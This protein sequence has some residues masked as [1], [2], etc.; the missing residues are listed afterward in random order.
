MMPGGEGVVA[1]R[2]SRA[3]WGTLIF[4]YEG[5]A[6]IRKLASLLLLLGA[7]YLGAD[8]LGE[9]D[10][11]RSDAAQS[12]TVSV[13]ESGASNGVLARAFAQHR[14]DVQV[15]GRGRVLKVLEDDRDGSQHQRFLLALDEGFTVLVA[16]NIDL[17]PRVSGLR[18]GDRVT[19]S[20]EYEWND[21]GGVVHWTH[22]DPAG[23]HVSGWLKH[24]GHT[25]Q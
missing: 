5:L 3:L 21:K 23:R 22:R 1:R 4:L 25:F 10:A 20:G 11:G 15:Q 17:A 8:R 9:V 24:D 12:T 16:H 19:F 14:S 13:G 18:A 6:L 7:L 2:A